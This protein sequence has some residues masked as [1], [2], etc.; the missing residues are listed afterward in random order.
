[1]YAYPPKA[2]GSSKRRGFSAC[3]KG[4]SAS[5]HALE[6]RASA[7]YPAHGQVPVA[8]L[9]RIPAIAAERDLVEPDF[10]RIIWDEI[11]SHGLKVLPDRF[12]RLDCLGF[13]LIA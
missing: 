4:T 7:P 2:Q 3:G 10:T 1:M 12:R 6:E 11:D 5:F 13:R 8:A 9:Q